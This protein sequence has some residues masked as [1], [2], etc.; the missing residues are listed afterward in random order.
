MAVALV[1]RESGTVRQNE[2]HIAGD[3]H[4]FNRLNIAIHHIPTGSQLKVG[5]R[6]AA[7]ADRFFFTATLNICCLCHREIDGFKGSFAIR[8]AYVFTGTGIVGAAL[9]P[10]NKFH[11]LRRMGACRRFDGTAHGTFYF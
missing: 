4:F 9:A 3:G 5:V 2:V 10:A 6:Q 8:H 1:E 11:P 7:R